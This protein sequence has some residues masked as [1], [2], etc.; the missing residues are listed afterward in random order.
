M[1]FRNKN[2]TKTASECSVESVQESDP[3]SV[4]E[5][6]PES[7]SDDTIVTN[8]VNI[9]IE[10]ISK[11]PEPY[12]HFKPRIVTKDFLYELKEA[13][14]LYNP[15]KTWNMQIEPYIQDY[16]EKSEVLIYYNHYIYSECHNIFDFDEEKRPQVFVLYDDE[17]KDYEHD[18][19]SE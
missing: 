16:L 7:V 17:F 5:S 14:V 3:D 19:D 4:P 1:E 9:T 18:S 12:N 6:D 8:N 2:R 15:T 11:D 13:G 10:P